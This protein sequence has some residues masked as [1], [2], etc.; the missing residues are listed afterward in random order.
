MEHGDNDE[1]EE[2]ALEDE[3]AALES[4]IN[5]Q[6]TLTL[7]EDNSITVD[8]I[9]QLP[10]QSNNNDDDDKMTSRKLKSFNPAFVCSDNDDDDDDNTTFFYPKKID[11]P[12]PPQNGS[13]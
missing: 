5:F 13:V 10:L 3:I 1:E 7:E 2:K 12:F 4:D 8:S 9:H 6:T 11:H